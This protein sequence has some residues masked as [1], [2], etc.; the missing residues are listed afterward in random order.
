MYNTVFTTAM[1]YYIFF[2][3][4]LSPRDTGLLISNQA[5][6]GGKSTSKGEPPPPLSPLIDGS[7]EKGEVG[8]GGEMD[9]DGMIR[10]TRGRRL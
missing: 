4:E 1:S 2:R 8:E 10:L 5:T 3:A 6:T 7:G 9:S